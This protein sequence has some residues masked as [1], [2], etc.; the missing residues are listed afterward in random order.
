MPDTEYP[1]NPGPGNLDEESIKGH[2]QAHLEC[3]ISSRESAYRSVR[4][5]LDKHFREGRQF[6]VTFKKA[7]VRDR[8]ITFK[9]G[10]KY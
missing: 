6:T 8:A 5:E 1:P 7:A 4:E 2:R 3:L 10:P 9:E